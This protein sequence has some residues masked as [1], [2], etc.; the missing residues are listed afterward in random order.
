MTLSAEAKELLLGLLADGLAG[1]S[2]GADGDV[3]RSRIACAEDWLREPGAD[4]PD[5]E[6]LET[7]LEVALIRMSAAPEEP[8]LAA[9]TRALHE[10]GPDAVRRVSDRLGAASEVLS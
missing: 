2:P 6:L 8:R 10:L 1:A 7:A 3:F 5:S 9:I 4:A